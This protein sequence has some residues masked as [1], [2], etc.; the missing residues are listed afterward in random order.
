MDV[1]LLFDT[2][3]YTSPAEVG[4]D[5]IPKWLA[6]IMTEEGVVGTFLVIG[7]KAKALRDRGR[8]DVIQ[9]MAKHEIG[10]HT[11]TG[12]E[13]PTLTEAMTSLSWDDGVRLARRREGPGVVEL[14]EI[15]SKEV[16]TLS[17]HGGSETPQMSY[18]AGRDYRLP[19]LYGYPKID[20]SGL[21]RFVGTLHLDPGDIFFLEQHYSDT[22]AFNEA[23]ETIDQR[24]REPAHAGRKWLG[25][26]C[27][28]P[29][30]I[31]A[32]EFND[33]L[34]YCDGKNHIPHLVP[35][36]RTG[37]EMETA[38]QNFRRLVK[39]IR[40]HELLTNRSIGDMAR[41]V[42]PPPRVI[43][44]S[45]LARIAQRAVSRV[46]WE[47]GAGIIPCG[48]RFS[49]AEAFCGFV[50][51]LA[52]E[53]E[54]LPGAIQLPPGT[55]LGPMRE[56]PRRPEN[57]RT[58]MAFHK[59]QHLA[60][61]CCDFIADVE[62]LPYQITQDGA[63]MGLGTLFLL[64][65]R[66]YLDL[67][68]GIANPTVWV[69]HLAPRYPDAAYTLEATVRQAYLHWPIHDPELPLDNLCRIYRLQSWTL[70]KVA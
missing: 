26:F 57:L 21:C 70:Q 41:E 65:A 34:N 1:S 10:F 28:H 60:S 9:A 52:E 61:R 23:L 54:K 35:R 46:S 4:L 37:E 31:R 58:E 32:L 24:I 68:Q 19:W 14:A 42:P 13:H 66:A 11:I 5:D 22:K 39:F 40:D 2:E 63:R 15:F 50:S 64:F 8:T 47:S 44:R 36:V 59:V 7:S 12:S 51:S 33:A 38:K 55:L 62:C 25:L 16:T 69:P 3:D 43:T 67:H 30:M 56:P 53:N 29:L 45:D 48:E 20:N 49:P 27:G 17:R 18:V 6:E